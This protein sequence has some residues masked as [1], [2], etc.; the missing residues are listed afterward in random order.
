MTRA[1]PG[2]AVVTG[3][4]AG[5]GR[6]LARA[7]AAEGHD[8]VLVARSRERLEALAEELVEAHGVSARALPADLAEEGA[9]AAVARRVEAEEGR[10][11]DTLVNNAGLGTYGPFADTPL[12]ETLTVVRVNVT[13]LT[14]LTRLFLPGLIERGRGRILNVASTAAFQ[15]GP[16][17]AVYYATK[18]YVLHFSE[19][20]ATELRNTGV[21]VTCLCPGPTKTEFQARAEMEAS[22]IA[23]DAWLMDA[24]DVAR[25]GI[26]GMLRGKR[27]VLPGLVN[28][29]GAFATRLAPRGA[30]ARIVAAVQAPRDPD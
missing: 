21:T 17:M 25:A 20:L 30:V 10:P 2:T 3:A 5:I 27:L 23:R 26:R 16:G 8:L 22:G 13:A 18:A 12:E 9:P 6:E 1:A 15:P 11:V 29:L 24:A 28:K 14:G 4:S 7:L 19:A